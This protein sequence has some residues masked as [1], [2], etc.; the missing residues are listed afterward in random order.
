MFITFLATLFIDL[1]FAIF[2]GVLLALLLYLNRT[3]HPHFITLT[4]DPHTKH[5]TLV[6][7]LG[8]ELPQCPQLRIVRLDGSIFFGAVNNISE[9]LHRLIDESPEQCHILLIGSGINFVDVGG[10]EMLL[11]ENRS[12]SQSGRQIYLCSLKKDVLTFLRLCGCAS[13]ICPQNIFRN[14]TDAI[15]GIVPRLD[16]ERCRVCALRVFEECAAMP[17]PEQLQ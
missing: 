1:E 4:P 14:K 15:R 17:L 11:N 5:R 6:S 3:S 8:R 16:P 10:C 13:R 2:S 12:M 7:I 9:E